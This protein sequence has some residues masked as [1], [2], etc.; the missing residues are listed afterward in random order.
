MKAIIT[1]AGTGSRLGEVTKSIPKC[2]LKIGKKMIIERQIEALEANGIND[3][4]MVIGYHADKIKKALKNKNIKFYLNKDYDKTGML[5]SLFCARKEFDDDI[6]IIYGDV[7]FEDD[8]LKKLLKD[9]NDFCLVV[10][11]KEGIKKSSPRISIANGIIKE[12]SRDL[13]QEE[14]VE[15]IGM[16][17]FSQKAIKIFDDRVKDLIDSGEIKKYPSPSY[18]FNW[19]VHNGHS[20]HVVF[21]DGS[22]YQEIDYIDD[23]ENAKKKFN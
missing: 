12:I 13:P 5:E 9:N 10:D 17:K 7:V 20:I 8:L 14:N 19:L 15:Y 4:S 18:L 3:I 22:L 1:A 16:S 23:L 2:L 21:A 11:R 6:I